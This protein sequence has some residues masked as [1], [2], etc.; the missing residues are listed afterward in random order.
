[1]RNIYAS[2]GAT[3]YVTVHIEEA[4][5]QDLS[6]CTWALGISA[7]QQTPPTTWTTPSLA[8]YPS[9]GTADLSLLVPADTPPGAYWLW[10][11]DTDNPETLIRPCINQR[12][13]VI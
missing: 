2:S 9:A 12:I 5:G 6:T 3:E 8:A 4:N 10:V 7:S 13:S 11:K 1:M